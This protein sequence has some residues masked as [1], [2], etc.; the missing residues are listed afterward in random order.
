M[1][2]L[3]VGSFNPVTK[4]HINICKYLLEKY[5]NYIYLIPVN[6]NKTNLVSI[7]KRIEMLNLV[8]KSR[9]GVLNIY[10]YSKDGLFNYYVLEKIRKIKKID[11]II[12]GADL[13]LRLKTFVEYQEILKN[14]TIIVIPRNDI[15]VFKVIDSYYQEY[16]SSFIVIDKSFLGSSTLARSTLDTSY[17]EL[18]V[19]DYIKENNLYN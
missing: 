5:I 16:K 19:L 10:D 1:K 12:I 8:K 7:D 11:S 18:K 4:A 14:Y 15:D 13:L 3:Y 17:L 9:M 2:S 6:S